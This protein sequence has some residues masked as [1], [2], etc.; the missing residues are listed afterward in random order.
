MI[1]E[2]LALPLS[3]SWSDPPDDDCGYTTLMEFRLVYEGPLKAA[4]NRN[5]RVREKHVIRKQFHKQL[6]TLWETHPALQDFWEVR[7]EKPQLPEEPELLTDVDKLAWEYFSDV[8]GTLHQIWESFLPSDV[9]CTYVETLARR[10][11]RSNGF[12]FVPLVHKG[13]DLVCG[14]NILFLRREDPGSLISNSGDVDN[15]IKT[16]LD[17]L[18][19]P[20]DGSEILDASPDK[21]EDPFFCLLEDDRLV[22]ELNIKTDRLLTPIRPGGL[23][24]DVM[25]ILQVR[26]DAVRYNRH[27]KGQP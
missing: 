21:D 18:R 10:Y 27:N 12:R 3:Y 2:R 26:M 25:L 9:G 20:T 16:L 1:E 6:K 8:T 14:L 7:E 5:T 15:R 19:I 22:I 13:L 11:V 17:A 23:T 4:S 24:N